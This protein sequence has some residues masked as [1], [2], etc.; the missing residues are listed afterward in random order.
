MPPIAR[1]IRLECFN[2]LVPMDFV[3][4]K[5]ELSRRKKA[6]ASLLVFLMFGI[7]LFSNL[8]N[9]TITP[10]GFLPIGLIFII[11]GAI[12]FKY[13]SSISQIKIRILNHKIER[14]RGIDIEKYP[15]SEID[16]LKIKRR[17]NN[18]IREIHISFRNHKHLYLNAFE[19]QFESL[20]DALINNEENK[21]SVKEFR[22]LLNFDH[23]LFYPVLGLLISFSSIFIFKQVL[24]AN[25][26]NIRVVLLFLS[27]YIFCL[28]IYFMNKKP[29]SATYGKNQII[30]DYIFGISMIIVSI[31]IILVAL[32]QWF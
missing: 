4:S 10:G 9:S 14:Q 2:Y 31:W 22:E 7:F 12:T 17:T 29:L 30:V 15:I 27:V 26:S 16:S 24:K 5:N 21:I 13:L 20:K 28:A 18:V 1:K 32:C 3:I 6:F 11:I 25:Y 19:E 23:F 8:L